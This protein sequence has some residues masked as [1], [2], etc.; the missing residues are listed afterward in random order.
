MN[1]VQCT[2][3]HFFDFDSYQTCPHCGAGPL[4]QGGEFKAVTGQEAK[5]RNGQAVKQ[6][7]SFMPPQTGMQ[8]G[9][10]GVQ[11]VGMRENYVQPGQMPGMGQNNMQAPKGKTFGLFNSVNASQQNRPMGQA[12]QQMPQQQNRP[13]GQAGQQMPQ[14]KM[15]Q[16]QNR[17]MGQAGQQGQPQQRPAG[18]AGKENAL[19]MD[20]VMKTSATESKSSVSNTLSKMVENIS[21]SSEG[22]TMSYFSYVSKNKEGAG[23]SETG[24]RGDGEGAEQPKVDPVVGWMVCWEGPNVGQDYRICAGTN[25]VGRGQDNRIVI[26]GDMTISREKHALVIYE[27]VNKKFYLKPGESSGLTYLNDQY[28]S[29]QVALKSGD[30]IKL[31]KSKFMFV[32][33]C[34]EG[35]D[36]GDFIKG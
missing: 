19:S 1:V 28:I 3:H 30:T 22:K 15:P 34:W 20:E 23:G 13:M 6:P 5:G 8:S 11:P 16:Q 25:S 35:F 12:G 2:N 7:G 36:W 18:Q 9:G 31:G 14:Q 24:D 21:T 29:E 27:P 17:P 26:S 4:N 32:P 10:A 33:L